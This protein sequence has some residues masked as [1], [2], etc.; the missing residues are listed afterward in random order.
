MS[1]SKAVVFM[2][3]QS[4]E[5]ELWKLNMDKNN[6]DSIWEERGKFRGGMYK[7]RITDIS[8]GSISKKYFIPWTHNKDSYYQIKVLGNF[9]SLGDRVNIKRIRK[10]SDIIDSKK[11]INMVGYL[12]N[13]EDEQQEKLLVD[14]Y[15]L[16]NLKRIK[17]KLLLYGNGDKGVK[18]IEK[19]SFL[20][21]PYEQADSIASFS[22]KKDENVTRYRVIVYDAYKFDELFNTTEFQDKYI[23]KTL[24]SFKKGEYTVS[25][26]NVPV[27]FEGN[28]LEA[29]KNLI[30]QNESLR[31]TFA[32]YTNSKKRQIRKVSLDEF[33]KT[34]DKI[35]INPHFKKLCRNCDVSELIPKVDKDNR[36][37]IVS[38]KS[39]PVFSALLDNAVYEKLL[40]GEIVIPFYKDKNNK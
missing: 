32:N 20:Y 10:I 14:L 36:K 28:K 25:T 37:I 33:D 17:N 34:L 7:N 23:N 9:F 31:K 5:Y 21:L 15:R 39:L 3:T 35:R 2:D 6:L 40:S 13:E 8:Q 1:V 27:N 26:D 4:K 18:V 16:P 22:I 30:V 29:F 12:E 38:E 11:T 19:D 24:E